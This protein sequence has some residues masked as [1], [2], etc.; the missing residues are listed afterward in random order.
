[1][2]F[3]SGNHCPW[4][5]NYTQALERVSQQR[6]NSN[7]W[8]FEHKFGFPAMMLL[9]SFRSSH[10]SNLII[11]K[12]EINHV[13]IESGLEETGGNQG[14]ALNVCARSQSCLKFSFSI[15]PMICIFFS[16]MSFTLTSPVIMS[17][18]F[19]CIKPTWCGTKYLPFASILKFDFWAETSLTTLE[20]CGW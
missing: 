20:H 8:H 11:F 7:P 12:S 15:W 1:M 19:F 10:L 13:L 2:F 18:F 6:W 9:A 17:S 14:M 3:F 4:W 5:W 16:P